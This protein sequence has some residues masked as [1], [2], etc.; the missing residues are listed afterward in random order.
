LKRDSLIV[1][2]APFLQA[3]TQRIARKEGNMVTTPNP[4]PVPST[5]QRRSQRI[6]LSVPLLISGKRASG[7]PI[8][9]ESTTLIVSAHGALLLIREPMILGQVLTLTNLSTTEEIIC[10]VIDIAEGT[11]GVREVGVEFATECSRFWRVSF[12]PADWSPR[13][14]EARQHVDRRNP[15]TAT[16]PAKRPFGKK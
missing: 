7:P 5:K 9:E 6:V 11:S 2:M 15:A 4:R 13:S 1:E 14:P 3:D 8:A 12:P 10:T 16:L